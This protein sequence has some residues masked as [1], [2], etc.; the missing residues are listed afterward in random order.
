M[1]VAVSRAFAA[2]LLVC[3][4]LFAQAGVVI[5]GTRVVYSMGDREVNVR[6]RNIDSKPVLVQSWID[7]GSVNE[8][9]GRLDVPFVI[10]PP[11]SRVE[12]QRGQTLRIIYTGGDQQQDRET[13]FYLNVLEVPPKPDRKA[14][15]NFMQLAVRTRLKLFLRPQGLVVPPEEAAKALTWEAGAQGALRVHNPTPYYLSFSRLVANVAGVKSAYAQ[16][17]VAPFASLDLPR[18]TEKLEGGGEALLPGH[19]RYGVINDYGAE[20]MNQAVLQARP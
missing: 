20:V 4:P 18:S 9:P 17:M 6:L 3:V 8:S 5:T 2:A 11:M 10:S 19:I 15:E 14:D 13:L 16:G 7:D 12:P 1:L